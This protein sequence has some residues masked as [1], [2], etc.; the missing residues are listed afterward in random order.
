MGSGGDPVHGSV[1][2][3]PTQLQP[4]IDHSSRS[5]TAADDRVT[6]RERPQPP[7]AQHH[8]AAGD[9]DVVARS[10]TPKGECP[11]GGVADGLLPQL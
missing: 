5:V 6:T 10:L 11:R 9:P 8:A 7:P 4:D 3:P 1:E 2:G